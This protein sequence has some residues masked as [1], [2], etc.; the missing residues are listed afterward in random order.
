MK[1]TKWKDYLLKSGIPLEYEVMQYLLKKGCVGSYE[2]TYMRNDENGIPNEFSYDI[3]SSYIKGGNFF[4]LM[5]ECKYRDQ[6]TD[7][8]FVPD[9]DYGGVNEIY[10]HGFLNPV[11]H[12]NTDNK[13]HQLD[14]EPLGTL[15]GKG[16]EITSGGSNPKT[17]NQAIKQ[18]SYAMA[19]K[20][21]SAME[22]QIDG[23]MGN[24][25]FIFY[26]IPIIVTTANL[27][28]LK[29]TVTI[30]EL[31]LANNIEDVATKTDCLVLNG[32]VGSDL[33]NYNL[34]KFANFVNERGK[35]FLEQNLKSFNE[36]ISFVFSVIAKH[37]CPQA[38]AIIHHSDSNNGF[39]KL[40]DYLNEVISPTKKTINRVKAKE[41]RMEEIRNEMEKLRINKTAHNSI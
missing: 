14:F 28:Q 25:E 18:L 32:N 3:S 27:Y 13:F 21:I 9:D 36:D 8:I 1:Q 38:I 15:C 7:W 2:H 29:D 10:S 20:V 23:L 12:F 11:D 16:I 40:F 31:K 34:T 41:K 39:E 35:A 26:N 30:N 24:S 19:D 22:H 5:I 37:Y 33:E 4:D 17:I 6:S